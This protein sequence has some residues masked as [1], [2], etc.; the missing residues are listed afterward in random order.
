MA[1][2]QYVFEEP[3]DRI[4]GIKGHPIM[5]IPDYQSLLL[6]VLLSSANGE[7]RFADIVQ[8]LAEQLKLPAEARAELLPSGKQTV[9][10]NR[11]HWAKTYLAKAGLLE[12][13]RRGYFKITDRGRQVVA[14]YPERIDVNFLN[15]FEEF[16]QFRDRSNQDSDSGDTPAG[17]GLVT[18]KQTPDEVMRIA[19]KQIEG[20]LAQEL[21]E[22]IRSASE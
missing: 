8:R 13:T 11:V 9:F 17:V 16:K 5:Q 14:S 7:V 4:N 21:L 20:A 6:P 15:Q 22:R 1:N 2:P 10:N 3:G 18:Q 19:H 12:I